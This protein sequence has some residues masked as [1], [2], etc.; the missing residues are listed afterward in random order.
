MDSDRPGIQL[1][2]FDLGR[3]LVRICDGWQHACQMAGLPVPEG[4]IA[5][6]AMLKLGAIAHSS[7]T[8]ELDH[9]AFTEAAAPLLG[10]KAHQVAALSDAFLLG[11][12]PGVNELLDDLESRRVATA[13]LSNTNENHWRMMNDPSHPSVLPLHRLKYRFA[14]HLL[15]LRKPDS[16]IYEHVERQTQ[17]SGESIVFFDDLAENI[18]A[19]CRR[20]WKA[21]RIDAHSS[22]VE[23]MRDYL[24]TLKI[25]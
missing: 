15:G 6:E 1:V 16:A 9:A 10:L 24:H 7:D 5:P 25:L 2:C 22:P 3:V 18:D 13:C 14:S 23:Q 8:G 17:L 12:F 19:A 20:G 21:R 4:Q 11:A